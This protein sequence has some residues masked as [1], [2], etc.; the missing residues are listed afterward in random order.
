MIL[1]ENIRR[2]LFHFPQIGFLFGVAAPSYPYLEQDSSILGSNEFELLFSEL[3][4]HQ[5]FESP[6][7]ENLLSGGFLSLVNEI[8]AD[9]S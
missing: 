3:V 7:L 8:S 6:E 5:K 9:L 4:D 1:Q 2:D